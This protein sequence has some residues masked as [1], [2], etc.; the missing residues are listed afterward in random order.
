MPN[1][2]I[3]V[4]AGIIVGG[5][6]AQGKP[7]TLVGDASHRHSMLSMRDAASFAV[8]AVDNP[9][10]RNSTIVIGGPRP[11]S[12]TDVVAAAE[13]IVGRRI[14]TQSVALGA[15]IE[16]LPPGVAG[17][18]S[19]METYDSAIDMDETARTYGVRLTPLE[20][21]LRAILEVPVA[22]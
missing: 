22:R 14:E 12:W 17:L 1:L 20:E 11:V 5:P 9:A 19:A 6:L 10:A 16:G 13:R 3:E 21:G 7:V 2:Y 4:W 8:A 15:P 18:F